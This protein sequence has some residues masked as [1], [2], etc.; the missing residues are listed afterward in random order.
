MVWLS[1]ENLE[2]P[3]KNGENLSL[4]LL[5]IWT[6]WYSKASLAKGVIINH[7]LILLENVRFLC[8]SSDQSM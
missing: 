2:L 5:R 6:N 4:A 3:V 7:K 8:S 1:W